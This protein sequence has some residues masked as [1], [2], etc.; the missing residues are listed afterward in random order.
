MNILLKVSGSIAAYKICGLVSGLRREGHL[1]KVALS[2]SALKFVGEATWEGL[3]GES[4]FT[5]DFEPGKRMDHIFLNDWADVTVLAPATAQSLNAIATGV[6]SG[7]VTTLFLARNKE[8]PYL[9][10]PAM[11]PRMWSSESVQKSVDTLKSY[12]DVTVFNPDSGVVACGH[13]GE[14]RLMEPEAILRE[15][16]KLNIS[17]KAEIKKK[18]VLVSFGGTTED[19]DGVRQITNFSSGRTGIEICK[20][21]KGNFNVTAVGSVQALQGAQG[22]E[23]LEVKS[24]LSS[25]D[26]SKELEEL[27]SQRS[28]DLIVHAAAVSDFLPKTKV[29]K[30]IS[31]KEEFKIEFVKAPN[32]LSSLK[33]WSKN[34][35]IKIVSFKLTHNQS[36]AEVIEK[37][38]SQFMRTETD[39][40]V[41]NELSDITVDQHKYKIWKRDDENP[42]NI[43]KTKSSM[44]RAIMNIGGL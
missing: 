2:E 18:N 35:N 16:L 23:G 15:I 1:V 43:G 42:F 24:F 14:G 29:D 13:E 39:F 25:K 36:V 31:S 19:I 37:V 8:R 38:N 4:V 33:S 17:L 34:K 40:V 26:L 12:S 32:I 20:T 6:G 11:N 41:H 3:S 9:I 44:A 27:L 7:V 10:F 21:L 5:D 22:F 30:K 28:Y